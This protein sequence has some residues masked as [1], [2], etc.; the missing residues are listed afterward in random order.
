[1]RCF[2]R[3]CTQ[4]PAPMHSWQLP[5]STII[6]VFRLDRA[7]TMCW[8]VDLMVLT[9]LVLVVLRSVSTKSDTVG[10]TFRFKPQGY[11]YYREYSNSEEEDQ[12]EVSWGWTRSFKRET[13]PFQM[14]SMPSGAP[15]KPPGS[16]LMGCDYRR[17]QHADQRPPSKNTHLKV[18]TFQ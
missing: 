5:E 2:R 13:S 12:M 16:T 9:S 3:Y 15:F 1:M 4:S 14:R 18:S 11:I 17:N 8:M 6:Q 10:L 7:A